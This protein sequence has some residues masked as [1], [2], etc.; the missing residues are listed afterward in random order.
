MVRATVSQASARNPPGKSCGLQN[1]CAPHS[2]SSISRASPAGRVGEMNRGALSFK[3]H[4][5]WGGCTV[6]LC[7]CRCC[8]AAVRTQ[9]SPRAE[10]GGSTAQNID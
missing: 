6:P 8:G 5:V 4:C 3:Q 10:A 9:D 1:P 7:R 2:A